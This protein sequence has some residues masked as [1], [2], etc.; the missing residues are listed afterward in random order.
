M[1]EYLM[2]L[3]MSILNK[4]SYHYALSLDMTQA[5]WVKQISHVAEACG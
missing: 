2:A 4:E 3:S 1:K 5:A